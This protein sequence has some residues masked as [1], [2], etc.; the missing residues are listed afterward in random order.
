MIENVYI[1]KLPMKTDKIHQLVES[2]ASLRKAGNHWQGA[3]KWEVLNNFQNN[4]DLEDPDFAGMYDRSLQS[5][6]SRRFWSETGYEPKTRMLEFINMQPDWTRHL[7]RDLFDE[8]KSLEARIG[9]F[10]FGCDELMTEYREKNP[11][12][13]ETSHHHEDY[14]MISLYLAL[15]YPGEYAPYSFPVFVNTLKYLA[16]KDIPQAHDFPRHVK[17]TKILNTF[18]SKDKSLM[19]THAKAIRGSQFFQGDSLMIAYDMCNSI[20]QP[21]E[22]P[23]FN[24]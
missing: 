14:R 9:R 11:T 21:S 2:Y 10:L 24:D 17:V 3:W 19:D 15:R 22:G 7:F 23:F 1:Y 4:W 20:M 13:R 18:L 12:S 5:L 6:M 8:S 16:S